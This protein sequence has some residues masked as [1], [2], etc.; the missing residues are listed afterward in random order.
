MIKKGISKVVRQ[1]DMT[2]GEM[3]KELK[4]VETVTTLKERKKRERAI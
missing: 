2:E 4:I 1:E 3:E